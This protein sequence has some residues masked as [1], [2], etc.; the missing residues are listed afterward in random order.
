MVFAYGPIDAY[1]GALRRLGF[2]PGEPSVPVPH[3]H[4]Y[5]AELDEQARELLQA[6]DW[7]YSPLEAEDEQ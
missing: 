1:E 4:H 3:Q 2:T 6:F 5:R 7:R